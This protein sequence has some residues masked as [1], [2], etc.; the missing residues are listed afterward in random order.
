MKSHVVVAILLAITLPIAFQNCASPKEISDPSAGS[1]AQ[2]LAATE[3][4]ETQTFEETYN[5]GTRSVSENTREPGAIPGADAKVSRPLDIYEQEFVNRFRIKDSFAGVVEPNAVAHSCLAAAGVLRRAADGAAFSP[6]FLESMRKV[7]RISSQ[8]VFSLASR[9]DDGWG[10]PPGANQLEQRDLPEKTSFSWDTGLPLLCLREASVL[11]ERQNFAEKSLD[12]AKA[13]IGSKGYRRVPELCEDC[14]YFW[15]ALHSKLKGLYIKNTSVLMAAPMILVGQ[16]SQNENV[17]KAGRGAMLSQVK[18]VAK[19]NFHYWGVEE[20][21]WNDERKWDGHN[22]IEAIALLRA[23]YAAK[24]R[25]AICAAVDQYE[26]W[27]RGGSGSEHQERVVYAACFFAR[28]SDLAKG[29][30]KKHVM[31]KDGKLNAIVAPGLVTS[32]QTPQNLLEA[33]CN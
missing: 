11:L 1:M 24:N 4:S 12:V 28:H 26:T 21:G 10:E 25:N 30:C 33:R 27:S 7:L 14:G 6:E 32:F 13:W 2:E 5:N 3:E 31:G 29:D 17:E 16:A 18:E 8:R 22:Y 9:W 20:P 19:K 15:Y 23:G